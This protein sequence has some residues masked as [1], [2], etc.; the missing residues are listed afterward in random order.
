M[1]AV[2]PEECDVL[3]LLTIH[4]KVHGAR[5]KS[6]YRALMPWLTTPHNTG[7]WIWATNCL[8]IIKLGWWKFVYFLLNVCIVNNFVLY[9]MTSGPSSIVLENRQLSSRINLLQ[10]QIRTFTSSKDKDRKR[11]LSKV[12]LLRKKLQVVQKCVQHAF[13]GKKWHH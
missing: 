4:K 9:N 3:L 13:K 2:W 8:N 1:T 12:T 6:K 5:T 10:Q 11:N 7:A